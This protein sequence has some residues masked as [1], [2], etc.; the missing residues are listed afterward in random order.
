MRYHKNPH[1][2]LAGVVFK[3]V[4][5]VLKGH[6]VAYSIGAISA[7]LLNTLFFMGFLVIAFYDTDYIQNWLIRLVLPIRLLS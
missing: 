1:G 5:K 4:N 3:I 6:T 2:F 7:P